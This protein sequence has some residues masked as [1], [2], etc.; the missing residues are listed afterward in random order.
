MQSQYHKMLLEE[1]KQE[2]SIPQKYPS[3]TFLY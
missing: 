3:H 2:K 1:L